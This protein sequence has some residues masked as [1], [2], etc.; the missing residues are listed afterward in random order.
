MVKS[1]DETDGDKTQTSLHF[2]KQNPRIKNEG[3]HL[4]AKLDK[5]NRVYNFDRQHHQSVE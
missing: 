1:G 3:V 5:R 2:T 4:Q